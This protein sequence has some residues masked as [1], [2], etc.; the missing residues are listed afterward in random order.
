MYLLKHIKI[1]VNN[2][3]EPKNPYNINILFDEIH[4]FSLFMEFIIDEVLYIC[5]GRVFVEL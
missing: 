1:G 4:E 2:M 3:T 5:S